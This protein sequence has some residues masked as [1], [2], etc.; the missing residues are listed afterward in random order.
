MSIESV[1]KY[2]AQL[3]IEDRIMEFDT[4]SAT[5]ELRK[6]WEPSLQGSARHWRFTSP[7]AD[8]FWYRLQ[9]TAR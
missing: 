6:H 4:S 3:G 9:E 2:F 5:V 8:A 7:K 1:R